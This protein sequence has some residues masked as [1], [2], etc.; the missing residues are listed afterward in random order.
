MLCTKMRLCFVFLFPL[1]F[2]VFSRSEWE[3]QTVTVDALAKSMKEHQACHR[4]QQDWLRAIADLQ[5]IRGMP[6]AP[7]A[8]PEGETAWRRLDRL[9]RVRREVDPEE[10]PQPIT[11]V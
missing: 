9:G 1:S 8:S 10:P 2:F 7:A 11:Y 3:E 5:R 4:V 6:S